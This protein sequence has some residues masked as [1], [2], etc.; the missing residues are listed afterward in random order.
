MTLD[1]KIGQMTQGDVPQMSADN[2][3]DFTQVAS[4][5]LGSV[6]IGGNYIPSDNNYFYSNYLDLDAY[7]NATAANFK[8]LGDQLFQ[9]S[10]IDNV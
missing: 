9:P 7:P 3:I 1:Q 8:H 6:L 10:V 4:N 5:N 2:F